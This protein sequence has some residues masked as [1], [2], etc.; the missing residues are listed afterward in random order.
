MNDQS[1][2]LHHRYDEFKQ[3]LKT[4]D[5]EARINPNSLNLAFDVW[6][7]TKTDNMLENIDMAVFSSEQSE[8]IVKFKQDLDRLH[9]ERDNFHQ[10]CSAMAEENQRLVE[11]NNA[12]KIA[13]NEVS[14]D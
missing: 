10:Q 5:T 9:R 4:V 7:K 1:F 13:L 2:Y 11:E 8:L 12:L 3:Y 14:D 6:L